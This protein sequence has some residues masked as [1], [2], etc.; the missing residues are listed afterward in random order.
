MIPDGWFVV[1]NLYNPSGYTVMTH[2]TGHGNK[3][4]FLKDSMIRFQEAISFM[5]NGIMYHKTNDHF[6]HLRN[7]TI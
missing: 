5:P 3:L 6:D 7:T 1:Y 4:L 2:I